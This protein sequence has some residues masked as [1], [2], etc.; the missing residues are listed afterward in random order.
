MKKLI[1]VSIILI[2]LSGCT[3]AYKANWG[4]L[5][6]PA[7]VTCYSGN[8]TTYKGHST[9]KVA[10]TQHSDGWEFK[11]AATQRFVRVSGSCVILN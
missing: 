3:D 8:I 7:D 2:M 9:G 4:A 5:G 1:V 11:D 10:T 6:S